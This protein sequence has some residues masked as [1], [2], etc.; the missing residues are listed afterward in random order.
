MGL[1][2]ATR[3]RTI[4]SWS[5][6]LGVAALVALVKKLPYPYRAIV[7]AGVVTGLGWG[8]VSIIA[9]YVRGLMGTPPGVDPQLPS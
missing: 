1:F 6:T 3:K 2:H 7:D 4:V 9:I 5:L 8:S